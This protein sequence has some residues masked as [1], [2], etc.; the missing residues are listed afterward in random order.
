M[1]W[2]LFIASDASAGAAGGVVGGKIRNAQCETQGEVTLSSVSYWDS[3][4]HFASPRAH[5]ERERNGN[6][7]F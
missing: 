7:L 1:M 2:F 3:L 5:A 4:N 6:I